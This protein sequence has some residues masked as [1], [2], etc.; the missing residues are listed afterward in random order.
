VTILS[1]AEIIGY[2]ESVLLLPLAGLVALLVF[3]AL[4]TW[5]AKG[6]YDD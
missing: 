6:T 5:A 4:A 1:V 2:W 3:I